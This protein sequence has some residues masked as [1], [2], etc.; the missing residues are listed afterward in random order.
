[1]ATSIVSPTQ[2]LS[3]VTSSTSTASKPTDSLTSESTFLQLLVSQI[4]NQDPLNPADPVQFLSQLT[5]YSQLEQLMQINQEL[6][7]QATTGNP[8]DASSTNPVS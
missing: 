7:P 8:A 1:M 4:K 5:S 2:S 6:A 3:D